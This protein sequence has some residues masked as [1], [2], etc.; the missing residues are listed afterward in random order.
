MCTPCSISNV[1][2]GSY[3]SHA[4]A[5]PLALVAAVAGEDPAVVSKEAAMFASLVQRV[6]A[7]FHRKRC[8]ECGHRVRETYCDVCGYD[9]IEQARDKEFRRPVI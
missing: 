7:P 5:G 3:I 8:P 2:P 6:T 1:A 9:L 4:D